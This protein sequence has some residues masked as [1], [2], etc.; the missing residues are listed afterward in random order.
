MYS[1]QRH[2][3][4]VM[5]PEPPLFLSIFFMLLSALRVCPS[6]AIPTAFSG[7]SH[8]FRH[9]SHSNTLALARLQ[10]A[11]RQPIESVP[12]LPPSFHINSGGPGVAGLRSDQSH[13]L[14][15]IIGRTFPFVNDSAEP[16]GANPAISPLYKSHRFSLNSSIWGYNIPFVNSGLYH[17]TAHFA[18]IDSKY[19]SPAKRVFHLVFTTTHSTETF[20]YIDPYANVSNSESK[21][22]T[23]TAFNLSVTGVLSV[24]L[25]PVIGDPAISGLSCERTAELPNSSSPQ[26]DFTIPDVIEPQV[27]FATMPL[28]AINCGATSQVPSFYSDRVGTLEGL[29]SVSTTTPPFPFPT[30]IGIFNETNMAPLYS[31]RYANKSSFSY[32]FLVSPS[33]RYN[34]SF[35]FMETDTSIM[36]GDRVFNLRVNNKGI[37]NIDVHGEVGSS[38]V[39]VKSVNFIAAQRYLNVRLVSVIGNP[40][41]SAF[42][43]VK[44]GQLIGP[45]TNPTLNPTLSP[46]DED[47]DADGEEIEQSPLESP[48][49]TPQEF[50]PGYSLGPPEQSA[51]SQPSAT[52]FPELK[53]SPGPEPSN[54]V[55]N[56]P[57]TSPTPLVDPIDEGG[58]PSEST[59]PSQS[60]SSSASVSESS[61][62][63]SKSPI[64]V[65]PD[66]D[67]TTSDGEVVTIFKLRVTIPDNMPFTNGIKETLKNVSKHGSSK[68]INMAIVSVDRSS[69]SRRTVSI[70]VGLHQDLSETARQASDL[71]VSYNVDAQASFKKGDQDSATSEFNDYVSSGKATDGM[72]ENGYESV[73]VDLRVATASGAAV[74]STSVIVIVIVAGAMVVLAGIAVVA[75]MASS[76]RSNRAQQGDFDAPPPLTGSDVSS[77]LDRSETAGSLEY[78]DD[79]STYTAATSRAGDHVDPVSFVKDVFGRGTVDVGDR[80]VHGGPSSSTS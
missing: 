37:N 33:T 30:P 61:T 2:R 26:L 5:F 80:G 75:Y 54:L 64:P 47:N 17:C 46:S 52:F 48:D 3:V 23:V 60:A 10:S 67:L 6:Q 68:L 38:T 9:D 44:V 69:Q 8:D 73:D 19:M 74:G 31:Y 77:A 4:S 76:N 40:F 71:N 22:L 56:S 25:I 18:E 12:R 28:F 43:C 41:I 50:T 72:R 45:T 15:W 11:F 29:T 55:S 79:D 63:A 59:S 66:G 16:A 58:S 51:T 78:L 57:T 70:N 42:S 24:R 20:H 21:V 36:S 14:S 13:T 27:D 53:G 49:E 7:Y 39:C 62:S 32:K 65:S 1:K 35:Y 34:C